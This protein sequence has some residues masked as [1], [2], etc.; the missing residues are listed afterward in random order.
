MLAGYLARKWFRQGAASHDG[1]MPHAPRKSGEACAAAVDDNAL[2]RAIVL[3]LI[4]YSL[5]VY[6]L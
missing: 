5:L 4:F 3:D 2:E 1:R 6:T